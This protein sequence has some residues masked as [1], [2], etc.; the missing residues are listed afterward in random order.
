MGIHKSPYNLC[1]Q[2]VSKKKLLSLKSVLGREKAEGVGKDRHVKS[3]WK[4][5]CCRNSGEW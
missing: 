2:S 3:S 5:I 1:A 4:S